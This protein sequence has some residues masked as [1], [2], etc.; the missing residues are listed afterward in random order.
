[1][2]GNLQKRSHSSISLI[3]HLSGFVYSAG[4]LLLRGVGPLC[5]GGQDPESIRYMVSRIRPS[6]KKYT[7]LHTQTISCGSL[8]LRGCPILA[9]WKCRI[10]VET[11]VA[12][13]YGRRSW[14]SD[15]RVRFSWGHGDWGKSGLMMTRIRRAMMWRAAVDCSKEREES[16]SGEGKIRIGG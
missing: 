3:A 4:E 5:E 10:G 8:L 14:R 6:I 7:Y 9:S 12:E 15:R 2:L 1:M 16:R 13:Y 11:G